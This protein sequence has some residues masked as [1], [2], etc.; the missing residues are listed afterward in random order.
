M[1]CRSLSYTTL[2]LPKNK[3][4][5]RIPDRFNPFEMACLASHPGMGIV[6]HLFVMGNMALVAISHPLATVV[7]LN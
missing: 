2:C 7:E 1:D 5:F 6:C 4:R 3:L